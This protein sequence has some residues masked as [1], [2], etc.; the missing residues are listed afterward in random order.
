MSIA[1]PFN[2]QSIKHNL[3]KRSE[4]SHKGDNGHV[5]VLGGDHGFGGAALMSAEAAARTGAGLVSVA[6]RPEHL[7]AFLARRPELMVR[8]INDASEI[9][10]LLKHATVLVVGPGLGQSSWSEKCIDAALSPDRPT[11]LDA[12][13]LNLLSRELIELPAGGQTLITPHPG[14]AARLLGRNIDIIQRDREQAC[15][16]LQSKFGG[17]AILKGAGTLIAYQQNQRQQLD[18]CTHGNP[19]MGSGGMGDI[20]SGVLGGLLA[21]GFSLIESARLGVCIHSYSADLVAENSGQRGM[22]ATDLLPQIQALV[23]N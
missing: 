22:L 21:Q 13:A 7:P 8:G 5:L 11:V 12:D 18:L 2:Y 4:H 20:L 3:F 19:G 23:N 16:D 9:P 17:I 14:E 1:R 15:L 10:F 6:T